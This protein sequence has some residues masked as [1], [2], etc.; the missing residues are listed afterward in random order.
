[1]NA[2]AV[3]V[4]LVLARV[5]A[6]AAVAPPF[7]GRTPRSVRA[8]LAVAL[9]AFYVGVVGLRAGPEFAAAVAELDSV[10][11]GVA[12]VREALLGTAMGFAFG[13]FLIPARVAGEFV[14]QQ[15]GLNVSPQVGPTGDSAGA[16]TNLLETAAALLFLLGDFHHVALATLHGSFGLFPLGG[17]ALPR[18]AP[19]VDGLAVAYEMGL[20]LA[21]PLA[22][23]LFLLAVTLAV[24]A[25]A[26]PQLNVYS[27]GFT[28]QVMVVLVAG[29]FLLPELVGAI[30]ASVA[31]S[32]TD[33]P[34][35]L[36]G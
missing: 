36:G 8:G 17:T 26:A 13:L 20:L 23:C 4:G 1:M 7:A 10:G 35:L 15:V 29:L 24:M 14:T 21:G 3:Y 18:A 33:L 30:H 31:R 27:I 2:T 12:L 5:G 34:R 19:L 11:Y 28:L 9:A 16:L 25:R 6:F 22:L 32:G